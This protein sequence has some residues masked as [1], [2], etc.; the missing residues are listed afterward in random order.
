[1]CLGLPKWEFCIGKKHFTSGKKSGKMALPTQKNIPIT[2]LTVT[3]GIYDLIFQI[4]GTRV[5][6]DIPDNF[7]EDII[8]QFEDLPDELEIIGNFFEEHY[9][10][11]VDQ[12]GPTADTEIFCRGSLDNSQE[13][14]GI[15]TKDEFGILTSLWNYFASF[16][17]KKVNV[18]TNKGMVGLK[19]S[20]TLVRLCF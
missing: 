12:H 14:D 20:V 17:S 18:E 7:D 5:S 8:S 4:Q 11:A 6:N 10:R 9:E 19:K 16:W 1:M 3:F 2:P 15:G 13:D